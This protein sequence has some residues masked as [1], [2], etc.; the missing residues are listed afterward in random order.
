MSIRRTVALLVPELYNEYFDSVV[1]GAR[2][3][4]AE[5]KINLLIIVG[6]KYGQDHSDNVLYH[7]ADQRSI[8]AIVAPTST[9]VTHVDDFEPFMKEI[10]GKPQLL[11]SDKHEGIPCI[12][13][14]N[15]TGIREAMDYL[16]GEKKCS[17]ILM[18]AGPEYS[19]D[20]EERYAE[21][22]R[23]MER[24][25]L[26][27]EDRMV[28]RGNHTEDCL[29]EAR[30]LVSD[31]PGV[32]AVICSNDRQAVALYRA[33]REKNIR[34][35]TDVFV[36]GFDDMSES[37][38]MD[39]P[40][41]SVSVSSITLGYEACTLAARMGD[42]EEAQDKILKCRLVNRESAGYDPYYQLFNFE[43]R[44]NVR[45]G[46]VF[47]I[48]SLTSTM[49]DFIFIGDAHEYQAGCQR[50]LL[51]DFFSRLLETYL[52][53]VIRRRSMDARDYSIGNIFGPESA[54]NIDCD[55]L[56][57]VLDSIF[58]VYCAREMSETSRMELSNLI[59]RIKSA[60]AESLERMS[61][62]TRKLVDARHDSIG[63]FS[64]RL[65]DIDPD[66]E[67]RYAELM[68]A[69]KIIGVMNASI[70]LYEHP[71]RQVKGE[72]F[73]MPDKL[74]LKAYRDRTG[75]HSVDEAHQETDTADVM[76]HRYL[77]GGMN[78]SFFA[79]AL[80]YGGYQR[81]IMLIDIDEEY[82]SSYQIINNEI[83][84]V[85]SHFKL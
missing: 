80:Y 84:L 61:G 69:L 83:N 5:K 56:F 74:Y 52:G 36:I 72:R 14:D 46:T 57:R 30:K 62:N 32:E 75:V 40:L 28:V 2:M 20:G 29:D 9:I 10:E 78:H 35:G 58:R 68:D 51:E 50:K 27:V 55:R 34:I 43:R 26:R 31:N 33:L 81:G 70:F 11:I 42:G 85:V 47:D 73:E 24:A 8:D 38:Y 6:G 53:E 49:V 1:R 18:F 59:A 17:R 21:Y 4:A 82:H 48:P 37:S 3:A 64:K 13:Y 44:R 60:A 16:T 66:G 71:I 41:A 19:A 65:L 12:Y 23:C 79:M 39:P 67:K 25:R 63:H 77:E 45:V 15:V 7:L 76:D 22:R 54:E